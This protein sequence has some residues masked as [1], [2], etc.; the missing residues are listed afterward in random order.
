M[1]IRSPKWYKR[2][3]VIVSKNKPITLPESK[4]LLYRIKKE[5]DT[6]FLQHQKKVTNLPRVFRLEI[7]K[8][9]VLSQILEATLLSCLVLTRL[10]EQGGTERG[11]FPRL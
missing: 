11:L 10:P 5:V 7:E 2:I 6:I 8:W 3:A 4:D 1:L 9:H